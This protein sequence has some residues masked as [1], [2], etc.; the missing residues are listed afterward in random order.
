MVSFK[1]N[2]RRLLI[3]IQKTLFSLIGP[4][5]DPKIYKR[6]NDDIIKRS[7]FSIIEA[8]VVQWQNVAFPRLRREFDSPHPLH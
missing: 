2:I 4:K 3:I 6:A 7:Y 8:G 5:Q 1:Y